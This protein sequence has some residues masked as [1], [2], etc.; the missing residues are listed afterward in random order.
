MPYRL[1]LAYAKQEKTEKASENF[2]R[3]LTLAIDEQRVRER[4]NR[5]RGIERTNR[6]PHPDEH[7]GA[8]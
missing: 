3:V 5:Q 4:M 7:G 8:R 2:R 1:A 6:R